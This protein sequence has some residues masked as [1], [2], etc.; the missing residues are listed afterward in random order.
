MIA[1]FCEYKS[2]NILNIIKNKPDNNPANILL[3]EDI[4]ALDI[5]GINPWILDK[6]PTLNIIWNPI[7]IQINMIVDKIKKRDTDDYIVIFYWI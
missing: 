5:E 7:E 6:L 2:V 4:V 3:T 1:A